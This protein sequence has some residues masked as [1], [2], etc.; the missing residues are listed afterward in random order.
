M[1]QNCATL[2]ALLTSTVLAKAPPANAPFSNGGDP[3][4][5]VPLFGDLINNGGF[6]NNNLN[7]WSVGGLEF[8]VSNPSNVH[9]GFS[10]VAFG[11][12]GTVGTFSQTLATVSG[13]NYILNFWYQTDG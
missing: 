3:F 10:A 5:V 1:I 12:I 11:S 2:L 8:T 13:T 9:S 7:G 4:T 6:E